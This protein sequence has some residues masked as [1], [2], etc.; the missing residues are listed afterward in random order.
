MEEIAKNDLQKNGK[1]SYPINKINLKERRVLS[2]KFFLDAD[3]AFI[4]AKSDIIKSIDDYTVVTDT[5]VICETYNSLIVTTELP[6]MNR[7]DLNIAITPRK[8]NLKVEIDH[9]V[10]IDQGQN[11]KKEIHRDK[12]NK[13]IFL[14]KTVE[15]LKAETELTNDIL[16]IKLPKAEIER[17]QKF[18]Y[19][20][21]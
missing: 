17:V 7:D 5:T 15:P 16:K 12:F 2:H 11:K 4:M 10:E 3:Q 20:S 6:K 8:V 13:N 9:E 21:K 19:K 14:P 18:Y 1:L